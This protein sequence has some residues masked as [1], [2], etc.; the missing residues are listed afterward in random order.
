MRFIA[1][2]ETGDTTQGRLTLRVIRDALASIVEARDDEN[3]HHLDGT[4]LY[5]SADA[6]EHPLPDALHPDTATHELIGT[7][8]AR[9]AFGDGGPFARGDRA[10][11][12]SCTHGL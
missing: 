11:G 1:T 3:L 7:R 6:D 8:F 10:R 2:G 9:H 5:G 12:E 4:A